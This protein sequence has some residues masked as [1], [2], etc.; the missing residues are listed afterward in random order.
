MAK[1][2]S[3]KKYP[4]VRITWHDICSSEE[5]WISEDQILEHDVAV[6]TDT[7]YIYKKTKDKLWLFTSY[8]TEDD[9][10]LSVGGLTTLP[11]GCIKKI[12]VIK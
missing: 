11:L 5:A 12:E 10:S 7:G 4:H 6:C 9:G 1:Q 2:K 8:T 3:K